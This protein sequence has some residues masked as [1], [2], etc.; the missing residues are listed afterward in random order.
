MATV[1]S[2]RSVPARANRRGFQQEFAYG[3]MWRGRRYATKQV[4][5]YA[6]DEDGWLV[7]TVVVKFFADR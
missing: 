5:A 6:V 7:I 3:Q 2:G 1:V 4:T